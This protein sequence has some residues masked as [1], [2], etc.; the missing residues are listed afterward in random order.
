ML[1]WGGC[2]SL[3]LNRRGCFREFNISEFGYRVMADL[4]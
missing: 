3:L 1:G 4:I 2:M